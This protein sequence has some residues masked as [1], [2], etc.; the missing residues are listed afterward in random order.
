M[1][2]LH[3]LQLQD[4]SLEQL[5]AGERVARLTDHPQYEVYPVFSADG[6]Q[7]AYVRLNE[8][9]TDHRIMLMTAGG[10]PLDLGIVEDTERALRARGHEVRRVL[11]VRFVPLV[12]RG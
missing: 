10:A 11:P 2:L 3:L 8:R 7:I 6:A 9:W 12:E 4:P 5:V 1:I